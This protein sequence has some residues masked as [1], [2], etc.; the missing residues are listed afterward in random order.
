MAPRETRVVAVG[1]PS[2]REETQW[3]FQRF[4]RHLPAAGEFVV[5]NRSWYNRAGVERVMGFCSE[6]QYELFMSSVC[7]YET[8]LV[9]SGIL[10]F[11]YY[12]DISKAVQKERLADRIKDPLTQWKV[13]PIDKVAHKLWD[14]YSHA[15]D[16]MFR[17]TSH[18]AA[19][20]TIV[21][22]D[23]K[24]TARIALIRDLLNRLEYQGKVPATCM[25]DRRV[26]FLYSDAVLKQGP[27]TA[28]VNPARWMLRNR[29]VPSGLKQAPQ[30]SDDVPFGERMALRASV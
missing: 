8:M 22:A 24:K 1:T 26:V 25:P 3:Y 6:A 30:N 9:E 27:V 5:F 18:T 15:R 4:V 13:S 7:D 11:K 12:L 21:R 20:W 10:L 23:H 2:N 19:P 16:E 29:V 28:S 14:D 17:R